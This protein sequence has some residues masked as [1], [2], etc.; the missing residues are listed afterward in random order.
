MITS[1]NS[2]VTPGGFNVDITALHEGVEFKGNKLLPDV[3]L[4]GDM[5]YGKVKPESNP[6]LPEL[7]KE[8]LYDKAVGEVGETA[9]EF[10]ADAK[11]GAVAVDLT[12]TAITDPIDTAKLIW[13]GAD[14]SDYK[15]LA[16]DIWKNTVGTILPDD[17]DE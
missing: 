17:E 11:E 16:T 1:V 6:A 8:Y 4:G 2:K 7:T 14:A 5:G 9:A 3:D 15:N 10:E 12:F 13:S